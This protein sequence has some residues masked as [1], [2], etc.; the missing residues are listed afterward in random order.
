MKKGGYFLGDTRRAGGRKGAPTQVSPTLRPKLKLDKKLLQIRLGPQR[1]KTK[2][3]RGGLFP[4]SCLNC[5]KLY[6]P[7]KKIA[8]MNY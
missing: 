4:L 3:G 1:G 5:S 8:P 2:A 6:S 7:P